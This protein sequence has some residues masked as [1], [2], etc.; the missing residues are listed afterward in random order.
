ML[1]RL[2]FFKL[3]SILYK[4]G[5]YPIACWLVVILIFE[6]LYS[7]LFTFTQFWKVSENILSGFFMIILGFTQLSPSVQFI[8]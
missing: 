5:E 6:S 2:N 4:P 7:V 3:V 8:D 1:Y